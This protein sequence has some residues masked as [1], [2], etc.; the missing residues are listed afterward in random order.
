MTRST[1]SEKFQNCTSRANFWRENVLGAC[2]FPRFSTVYHHDQKITFIF[3]SDFKTMFTKRSPSEIL[4]LQFEKK[5]VYLNCNFPFWWSAITTPERTQ[6]RHSLKSCRIQ[7][8]NTAYK[9]CK[10]RVWESESSKLP[11]CILNKAL[12][13]VLHS[14]ALEWMTSLH[15]SWCNNGRLLN[16]KIAVQ[17]NSLL[18]EI[19]A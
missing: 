2:F 7:C 19:K 1:T 14:K 17:I 8:V 13:H 6:W 16:W 9:L 18:V 12:S 15:P 11:C 10:T 3:S 5:A 4:S